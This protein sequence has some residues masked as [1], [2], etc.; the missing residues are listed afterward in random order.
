MLV[1]EPQSVIRGKLKTAGRMRLE[2]W[3]EGD[4]VCSRLEIGPDGYVLGNVT[5]REVYVEGQVVGTIEASVV[6]LM[7]GSHV[8]GDVH[9]SVLS[10]H[11]SASLLGK[12][13]RAEG[14]APPELLEIEERSAAAREELEQVC[15][16]NARIAGVDWTRYQTAPNV[17]PLHPRAAGPRRSRL[18]PRPEPHPR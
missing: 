6:H 1:V 5:A 9:H 12:S 17:T 16:A 11:P 18:P 3:L 13:I 10:M 7:D 4:V 8:E 15:R 14:F 2:C